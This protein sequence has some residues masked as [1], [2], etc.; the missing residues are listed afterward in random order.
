[1]TILHCIDGLVLFQ[2]CIAFA[3]SCF[4]CV[5]LNIYNADY[6]KLQ[7]LVAMVYDL[8]FLSMHV[9]VFLILFS[10]LSRSPIA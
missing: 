9:I 6:I 1:M 2:K 8:V 3:L 10:D 4:Y 5:L 7:V